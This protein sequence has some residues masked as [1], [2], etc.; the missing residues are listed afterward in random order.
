MQQG[1][2]SDLYALGA[3][4]HG[5]LPRRPQPATQRAQRDRMLPMAR[6][7]RQVRKQFGIEYSSALVDAA[8][9]M[10]GAAAAG[11]AAVRR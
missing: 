3:T 1:P 8:G 4:V 11:Q 2:W 10:S 5:C 6:V 7:A 9:A